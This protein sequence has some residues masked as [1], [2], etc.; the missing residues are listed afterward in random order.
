MNSNFCRNCDR[1]GAVF[2]IA[3]YFQELHFKAVAEGK[4]SICSYR[5]DC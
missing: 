1:Y 4:Q 5:D 3:Q 2:F